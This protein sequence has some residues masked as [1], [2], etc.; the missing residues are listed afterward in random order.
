MYTKYRLGIIY[1]IVYSVRDVE[2]NDKGKCIKDI[3]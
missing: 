1:D 3:F 2:E